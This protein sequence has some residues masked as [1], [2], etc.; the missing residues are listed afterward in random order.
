M[1]EIKR[2][3]WNGKRGKGAGPDAYQRMHRVRVSWVDL[4]CSVRLLREGQ[5]IRYHQHQSTVHCSREY[6]ILHHSLGTSPSMPVPRRYASCAVLEGTPS[7][8][9]P[10]ILG[11]PYSVIQCPRFKC[12]RSSGEGGFFLGAATSAIDL[13]SY[14][15]LSTAPHYWPTTRPFRTKS[16]DAPPMCILRTARLD[17]CFQ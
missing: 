17:V 10:A 16:K 8:F 14:A 15:Q 6:S 2:W 11:Q 9:A 4:R 13:C 1:S 12:C 5:R 3:R 7:S